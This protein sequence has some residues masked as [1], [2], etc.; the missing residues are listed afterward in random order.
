MKGICPT[1]NFIKVFIL[2]FNIKYTT[3]AIKILFQTVHGDTGGEIV[4]T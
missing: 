4:D 1:L 2:Q 3:L